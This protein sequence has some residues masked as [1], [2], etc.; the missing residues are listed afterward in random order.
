MFH[1][2]A[3]PLLRGVVADAERE[4]DG[5]EILVLEIAQQKRFAV[6]VAEAVQGFV[7]HGADEFP[8]RGGF[9]IDEELFHG[10]SFVCEPTAGVAQV[11]ECRVARATV[12]PAGD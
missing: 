7:E 9:G 2:A 6:F 12:Q 3:D 8:V 1:G 4:A 11:V 10:L 5:A